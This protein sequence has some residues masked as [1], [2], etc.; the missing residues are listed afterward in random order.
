MLEYLFYFYLPRRT[1]IMIKSKQKAEVACVKSA[2]TKS[3]A[4]PGR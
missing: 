3:F 2:A 1:L 4:C